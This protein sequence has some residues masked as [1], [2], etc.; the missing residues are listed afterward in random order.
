[1]SD[2]N[3]NR[4]LTEAKGSEIVAAINA[5]AA[6]DTTNPVVRAIQQ[7]T[8]LVTAALTDVQNQTTQ[9]NSFADRAGD[10]ALISQGYAV[11]EQGSTP[12]SSG[13]YYHNN[14][15]Y[16]KEQAANSAS[17]AA[18][19]ASDAAN[20]AAAAL[21][22]ERK[23]AV[24]ESN[25]ANSE[26]AAS[27]SEVSARNS[28]T[29]AAASAT[30]AANYLAQLQFVPLTEQ[31][32]IDIFQEEQGIIVSAKANAFVYRGAV[33]TKANLPTAG[34]DIGDI[35]DV[36]DTGTNYAWNGTAWDDLAGMPESA[37]AGEINDIFES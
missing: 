24:S 30:Q 25:A 13:T 14:A 23:A 36:E 7:A 2:A 12:V 5:I 29:A 37:S 34:M 3:I 35:Y 19:Q 15:K 32:I 4:L 18:G 21:E 20:S 9:A 27:T 33:S 31:Q 22:S 26:S 11:G 17:A 16:Y 6:A 28:A 8:S 1:M 10:K